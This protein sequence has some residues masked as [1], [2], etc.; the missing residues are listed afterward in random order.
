MRS[1]SV[2]QKQNEQEK[3]EQTNQMW[4]QISKEILKGVP[5]NK[6][7]QPSLDTIN[8]RLNIFRAKV[9]KV[10][11]IELLAKEMEEENIRRKESKQKKEKNKLKKEEEKLQEKED[12]ITFFSFKKKMQSQFKS[13]N[14]QDS[15]VKKFKNKETDLNNSSMNSD[16]SQNN[17][18]KGS[19][20]FEKLFNDH[21]IRE[22]GD[23]KSAEYQTQTGQIFYQV[24]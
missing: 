3:Q 1:L 13:K 9:D 22:P 8:N 16:L 2:K 11:Y 7:L 19:K 20:I 18:K 14:D 6:N 4:N 12:E 15:G 23:P 17:Q 10:D 21:P 24:L 5:K